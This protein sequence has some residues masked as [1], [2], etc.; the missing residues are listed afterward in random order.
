MAYKRNPMRSERLCSLGRNLSNI[1]GAAEQTYKS[2]WL[3]RS[4][5]DS[6]IR[7]ITLPES[8]LCAD[9]CMILV[10][11]ISIRWQRISSSDCIALVKRLS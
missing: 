4:L 2:Q 6:A 11:L 1:S 10:G 3:E 7:R 5:D 9:A 8:F